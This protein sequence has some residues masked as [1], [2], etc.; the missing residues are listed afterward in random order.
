MTM[1]E[2]GKTWREPEAGVAEAK[3]LLSGGDGHESSGQNNTKV[4]TGR[5]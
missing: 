5:R 1:I 4:L 2:R 3:P